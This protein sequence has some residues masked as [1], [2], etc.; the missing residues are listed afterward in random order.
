MKMYYFKQHSFLR[1]FSITAA[2][3]LGTIWNITF[4]IFQ[5]KHSRKYI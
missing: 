5:E 2:L 1:A 3:K 4:S